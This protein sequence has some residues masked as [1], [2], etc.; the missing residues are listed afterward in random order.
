MKEMIAAPSLLS[1]RKEVDRFLDRIREGD[2]FDMLSSSD[3]IPNMDFSEK[4]DAFTV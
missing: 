3:W 2:A 4:T 1:F